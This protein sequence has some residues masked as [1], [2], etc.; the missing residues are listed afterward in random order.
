MMQGLAPNH[1]FGSPDSTMSTVSAMGPSFRCLVP[2]ILSLAMIVPLC[3]VKI[4][5]I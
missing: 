3:T 4:V 2:V 5:E 1:N